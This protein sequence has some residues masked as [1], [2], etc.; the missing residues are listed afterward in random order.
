MPWDCESR[1]S[2][3]VSPARL[4]LGRIRRVY[5]RDHGPH[6]LENLLRDRPRWDEFSALVY[7]GCLDSLLN[8]PL[9][10]FSS[11][12]SPPAAY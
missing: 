11:L 6:V 10:R 5:E 1:S 9:L 12:A 3:H 4:E 7:H 2:R 8:P